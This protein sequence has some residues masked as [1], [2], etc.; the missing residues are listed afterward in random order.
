MKVYVKLLGS[1]FAAMVFGALICLGI[2][3]ALLPWKKPAE[4]SIISRQLASA[5]SGALAAG[6]IYVIATWVLAS[7]RER[8]G[9]DEPFEVA[10]VAFILA[11]L[12][13]ILCGYFFTR[14][15]APSH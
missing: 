9:R 12:A 10:G 5:M 6:I 11:I 4:Y 3:E 8:Q 15:A 1:C 14:G 13:A 7:R 2:T